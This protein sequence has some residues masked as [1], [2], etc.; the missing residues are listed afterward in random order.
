MN[1]LKTSACPKC[2]GQMT[3]GFVPDLRR[4]SAEVSHWVEGHPKTDMWAG[5]NLDRK[6]TYPIG[7]HRCES[8]GFLEF[9]A[10]DEFAAR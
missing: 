10:S 1:E 6:R 7:A 9:Y 4:A 5:I 2:Q 3:Q 8:C